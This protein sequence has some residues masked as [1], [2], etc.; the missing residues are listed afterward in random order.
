MRASILSTDYPSTIVHG[1]TLF[2]MCAHPGIDKNPVVL[3]ILNGNKLLK[4]E[5]FAD[6]Q[7]RKVLIEPEI[8]NHSKILTFQVSRTW[9]PKIAGVSEDS[10]DLGVAVAVLKE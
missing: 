10:R 7:W 3:E 9:N 4:Q 2:L 1:L 5:T 6:H 8:L